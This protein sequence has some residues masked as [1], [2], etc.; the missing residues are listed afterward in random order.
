MLVL[1]RREGE[2]LVFPNLGITLEVVR[3]RGSAVRLGIDA[4]SDVSVWR[5]EL[6]AARGL[7]PLAVTEPKLSSARKLT[8]AIRNRLHAAT[9][10]LHL[11]RKQMDQGLIEEADRTWR[12]ILEEFVALEAEAAPRPETPAASPPSGVRRTLIVEDDANECEL[13][14]GFL[15]VSGFD[16]AT[17]GDGAA[18]LDYLNSHEL[19]DVILL[20]MIMPNVDG[21]TTIGAIRQ[22]P[23]LAGLKVFAIS[24]TS[25]SVFDVPT[26][27]KGVDRWFPKPI[28]PEELVREM[29]RELAE[30]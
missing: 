5:G 1:S 27:P 29:T 13:L 19:P 4:P 21:R 18:A 24:G 23:G 20:D 6:C 10:G 25:P 2:K 15:R 16:V 28:N 14:A 7:Q 22:N 9:L 3:V 8:H 12:K 26:G 30:S 17:S 11:Y